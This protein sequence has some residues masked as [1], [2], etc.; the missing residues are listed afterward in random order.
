M[1]N[2]QIEKISVFGSTGFIGKRF[3]EM[4]PDVEQVPRSLNSATTSNILYLISTVDNYNVH[5]NLTIDI[6]TNL[7]KFM[8]VLSDIRIQQ[9]NGKSPVINFVSS[10]F[11][12]G[13]NPK[14]PFSEDDTECNPTGFYSITKYCAEKLLIS[15]CET[16]GISYRIFRLSNIIGEGDTKISKQKNAL[17]H[18]I[19]EITLN[20]D[21][22]LYYGG[23]V[24]RDYMYVDDA[25]QA[26]KHCINVA[27]VNEIINIGS[28]QPHLFV[29]IINTAIEYSKSTSKIIEVNPSNFH[30]IVQ[31]RHS[32]LNINKLAAL[33]F[34][35]KHSLNEVV[36]KL[37]NHYK[38]LK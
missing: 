28:G 19:K 15:F 5:N 11:V 7:V 22:E 6:E 12:Y 35:S 8:N 14:V 2:N 32:Y 16:F 18:L 1:L 33:G 30:N 3:C 13:K 17:Q 38:L 24:R 29:D 36:E 31:V 34:K 37:V 26:I 20:H 10:W 27:P 23:Q 4:F 21:V 25:C 9:L